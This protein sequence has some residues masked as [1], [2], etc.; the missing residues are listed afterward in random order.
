MKNGELETKTL[1][2]EDVSD[3][4]RR[5]LL[6]FSHIYYE[7]QGLACDAVNPHLDR[8]NKEF[9][10]MY[11]DSKY[12]GYSDEYQTF[13]AEHENE[14][15]RHLDIIYAGRFFAMRTVRLPKERCCHFALVVNSSFLMY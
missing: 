13:I 3:N 8:W 1:Y 12:D 11:P 4:V 2:G 14:E 5:T 9:E 6:K 10:E 7:L 15:L